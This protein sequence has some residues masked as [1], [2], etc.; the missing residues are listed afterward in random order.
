[1]MWGF[2]DSV[3]AGEGWTPETTEESEVVELESWPEAKAETSGDKGPELLD[4]EISDGDGVFG[5]VSMDG[6]GWSL[7]QA[8]S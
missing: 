1:M 6:M 3:G 5:G 8:D 7:K 2:G 4:S